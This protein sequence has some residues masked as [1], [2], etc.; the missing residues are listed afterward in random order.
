MCLTFLVL[1]LNFYNVAI[2]D[3]VLITQPHITCNFDDHLRVTPGPLSLRPVSGCMRLAQ[4]VCRGV[5]GDYCSSP[6][7]GHGE[8]RFGLGFRFT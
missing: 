7:S 2:C 4:R 1:I 8:G 6:N 5:F 3:I